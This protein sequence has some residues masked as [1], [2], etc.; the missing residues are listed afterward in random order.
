V[1]FFQTGERRLLSLVDGQVK[2][3]DARPKQLCKRQIFNKIF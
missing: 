3:L 2:V 1:L